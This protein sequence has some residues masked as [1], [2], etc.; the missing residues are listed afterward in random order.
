MI[1]KCNILCNKLIKRSF[2]Y[3]RG[4][5]F[6]KEVQLFNHAFCLLFLTIDVHEPDRNYF[7]TCR[8]STFM[9]DH[10]VKKGD[11]LTFRPILEQCLIQNESIRIKPHEKNGSS[12]IRER[13][14]DAQ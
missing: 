3:Y 7:L 5:D 1:T 13:Q 4:Y 10:S 2:I 12:E 14:Y 9:E 6:P 11:F 8:L